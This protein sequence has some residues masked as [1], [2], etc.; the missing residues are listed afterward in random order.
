MVD[1]DPEEDEESSPAESSSAGFGSAKDN[2]RCRR[3]VAAAVLVTAADST[4]KA[5]SSLFSLPLADRRSTST[6][7]R[8]TERRKGENDLMILF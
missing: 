1:A 2:C 4:S 7:A 5:L 8:S 3:L 6:A